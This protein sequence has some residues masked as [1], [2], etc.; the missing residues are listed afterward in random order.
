ML[1][2]LKR[3]FSLEARLAQSINDNFRIAEEALQ[4]LETRLT[5]T[6]RQLDKLE[7]AVNQRMSRVEVLLSEEL[8]A[9]EKIR[10]EK[11]AARRTSSANG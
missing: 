9:K 10:D 4:A 5:N 1:K 7:M 3:L 8:A 6:C 2:K 11:I